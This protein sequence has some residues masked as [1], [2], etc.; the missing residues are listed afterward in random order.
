MRY[1]KLILL[2][3]LVTNCNDVIG[4]DNISEEFV[5]VLAPADSSVLKIKD[6]SFSWEAISG[7]DGYNLQIATPDF[8][9]AKQIILDT[10]IVT[11]SFVKTLEAGDYEWRIK[12]QNS[13]FETGY[14]IQKFN[15]EE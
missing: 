10:T 8:D 4:I 5:N 14:T 13:G 2:L 1:L 12:A 15:V 9:T 3:L 6:I 11:T 7:T